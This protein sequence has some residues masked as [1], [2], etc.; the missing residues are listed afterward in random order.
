MD[1]NGNY[2]KNLIYIFFFIQKLNFK[3]SVA[4]LV[5]SAF[6]C[7]VSSLFFHVN[8]DHCACVLAASRG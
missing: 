5:W 3:D 6:H 8:I 4:F 7:T 2:S 1:F